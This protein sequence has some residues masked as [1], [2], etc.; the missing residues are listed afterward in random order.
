MKGAVE[1]SYKRITGFH[2]DFKSLIFKANLSFLF[3]YWKRISTL[4][5]V[6]DTL[7]AFG[8]IW[9]RKRQTNYVS[10]SNNTIAE[11]LPSKMKD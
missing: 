5:D 6:C 2:A 4:N 10:N 3:K 11:A 1:V 8:F 7:K 9:K